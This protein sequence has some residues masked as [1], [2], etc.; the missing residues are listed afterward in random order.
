MT[1]PEKRYL[2]CLIDKYSLNDTFHLLGQKENPYPYI[3]VADYFCL[4][5]KFEGYGMVIEEAKILN[6]SIIITNTAARE[7]IEG[8]KN[9]MVVENTENSIYEIMKE[10][11]ICGK[12]MQTHTQEY[13]NEHILEKISKLI[14]S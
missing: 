7:A 4:L 2:K 5:S 14:D 1:G 6:K 3:R 12:N 10:I 8:Y 11:I 13:N 9:G